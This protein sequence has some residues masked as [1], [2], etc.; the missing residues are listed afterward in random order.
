MRIGKKK[1]KG[2]KKLLFDKVDLKSLCVASGIC[3]S[4]MQGMINKWKPFLKYTVEDYKEWD[5]FC[6]DEQSRRNVEQKECIEIST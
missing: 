4:S 6:K 5:D 2:I 1:E 3:P